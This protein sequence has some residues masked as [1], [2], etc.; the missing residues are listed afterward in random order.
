MQIGCIPSWNFTLTCIKLNCATHIQQPWHI[1]QQQPSE[2]LNQLCEY[3][4]SNKF[5]AVRIPVNQH[6][7]PLHK[8]T[9]TIGCVCAAIAKVLWEM[10]PQVW[11]RQEWTCAHVSLP[12]GTPTKQPCKQSLCISQT[13]QITATPPLGTSTKIYS[14]DWLK[15]L[16]SACHMCYLRANEICC[17]GRKQNGPNHTLFQLYL[18]TMLF[19]KSPGKEV[20]QW[21]N[22]MLS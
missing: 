16:S 1:I 10:D 5:E 12:T 20:I 11:Y 21:Q 2:V 8:C 18:Q 13:N 7:N 14:S 3:L 19:S 15:V 6:I 22:F 17:I 9:D 4:E